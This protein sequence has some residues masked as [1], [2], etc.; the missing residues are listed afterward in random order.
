MVPGVIEVDS[1][2]RLWFCADVVQ[3]PATVGRS[4][5][6]GPYQRRRRS[7]VAL[8]AHLRR[9]AGIQLLQP[10]MDPSISFMTPM[11]DTLYPD[12]FAL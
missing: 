11:K 10:T 2:F 7:P 1:H 9:R 12:L 3:D 5:R 4:R 8:I 6:V